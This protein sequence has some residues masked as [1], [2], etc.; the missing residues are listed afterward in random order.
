MKPFACLLATGALTGGVLLGY[1]TL[2]T[3]VAQ[4]PGM[5]MHDSEPLIGKIGGQYPADAPNR[6]FRLVDVPQPFASLMLFSDGKYLV[7]GI[8]YHVDHEGY[9]DIMSGAPRQTLVA[10]Y[11]SR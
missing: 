7:Q 11:R 6:V 2:G 5:V 1:L 4:Q 10:F 8:D 3:A 9:V